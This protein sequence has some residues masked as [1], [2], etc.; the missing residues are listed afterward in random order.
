[1]NTIFDGTNCPDEAKLLAFFENR[2]AY[3]GRRAIRRHLAS[4][5]DCCDSLAFLVKNFDASANVDAAEAFDLGSEALGALTSRV[6]TLIER[7]DRIEASAQS[8]PR[9]VSGA[10]SSLSDKFGFVLSYKA[11]MAAALVVAAVGGSV[12]LM[13]SRPSASDEAMKYV[14]LGVKPERQIGP[15]MPGVPFSPYLEQRGG[16]G[17]TAETPF[18]RALLKV[19][20][21]G[22]TP[23]GVSSR[24]AMVTVLLEWN[25]PG[26]AEKA[27]KIVDETLSHGATTAELF[28]ARGV[29]LYQTGVEQ[30][31]K[32]LEIYEEAVLAFT[33][34]IEKSPNLS[35]A[36]FNRALAE[37]KLKRFANA[38]RDMEYYVSKEANTEW[39]KEAKERIE[40]MNPADNDER[41]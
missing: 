39:I 19:S 18:Q 31:D 16:E 26:D 5:S 34:A 23:S 27:L 24:M 14:A 33:S 20:P 12:F 9:P 38:K 7:T 30:N 1:M 2:L 15:Q 40:R 11:L 37:Q 28:L 29:A 8:R 32:N 13:V 35:I 6:I 10:S 3:F 36:Y 25:K 21:N 17:S 41:H 4:C 22:L